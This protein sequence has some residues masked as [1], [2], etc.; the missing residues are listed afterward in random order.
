ML[1]QVVTF[2]AMPIITRLFSPDAL[3]VQG[4]FLSIISIAAGVAALSYPIAIVLPKK[5]INALA[6]ARLSIFIALIMCV[7]AFIILLF[8]N[9]KLANLFNLQAIM[10]FLFLIPVAMFANVLMAIGN[11][12]AVRKSL[13]KTK[14]VTLLSNSIFVNGSKI[15]AGFLNPIAIWLII[16]TVAGYFLQ[17]GML[18]FSAR[19][20]KNRVELAGHS[21]VSLRQ[22]AK[23]HIDFPLY[24]APEQLLNS[25]TAGLPIL[26]LASLF[27]ATAAGYYALAV[28]ALN[29]PLM[30]MGKSV[31]DVIYPRFSR[32]VSK[33][34]KLTPMLFKSTL[35]LM[36][37]SIPILII[38]MAFGP[39]I[40]SFVFGATW[41]VSGEYARWLIPWLLM[42]LIN[43]PAVSTFPVLSIQGVLLIY[44][45]VSISIRIG[46]LW[47]SF[48]LYNDPLI[49]VMFFSLASILLNVALILMAASY[50]LRYDKRLLLSSKF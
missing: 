21:T 26:M 31:S 2:G 30:L 35:G 40:F 7:F 18:Y 29:A 14:A 24:R 1:A 13:F 28:S 48:Y 32:A 45:I 34:E 20:F 16:T 6:I 11:Q 19:K 8:F 36:A 15:I 37:I 10:P 42:K 33:K 17:A 41:E 25:L 23:Q 9:D 3:G 50:S 5:D 38:F 12:W 4:A 47:L 46:V 22:V 49:T 39:E 43:K 27:N 44:S